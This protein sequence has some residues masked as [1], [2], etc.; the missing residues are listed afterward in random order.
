MADVALITPKAILS[1]PWLAKAQETQNG[2]KFGAAFVFTP[3]TLKDPKEAALFAALQKAAF[4]AIEKKWPGRTKELLE[5]ESF[6]KGFRR[7]KKPGY[8]EG[9]VYVNARSDK[10]PLFVYSRPA[11]GTNKPERVPADKV[12]E[13]FY[14]GAIVRASFNAYGYEKNGNRGVT[15]GLGNLQFIADG[16]RLDNRLAPEDEFSVDLTQAPA[17]DALLSS[18]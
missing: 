13:V 15:F 14:P 1:Y 3:E 2:P 9:S 18:L 10:Q 6:K 16:P 12:A 5:S 11:P 8:P 7:D 17:D 4:A